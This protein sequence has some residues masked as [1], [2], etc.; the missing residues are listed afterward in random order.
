MPIYISIYSVEHLC[1]YTYADADAVTPG[2]I[3]PVVF[4]HV[5]AY[6]RPSDSDGVGMS[7]N[8]KCLFGPPVADNCQ[9]GP[10]IFPSKISSYFFS[11]RWRWVMCDHSTAC[12]EHLLDLWIG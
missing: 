1:Q 6:H 11:E 7:E 3:T 4:T 10:I 8:K 5:G 9:Y 2:S 12:L